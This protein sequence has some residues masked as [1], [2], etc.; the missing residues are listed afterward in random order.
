MALYSCM[1]CTRAVRYFQK[2]TLGAINERPG[3]DF[4]ELC[5]ADFNVVRVE[6]YLRD[7]LARRM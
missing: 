3:R 5:S 6:F 1:V 4:K 7:D 2:I